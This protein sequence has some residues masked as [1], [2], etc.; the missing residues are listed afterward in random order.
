VP[1]GKVAGTL[2]QHAQCSPNGGV[3]EPLQEGMRR[4]HPRPGG[5]KLDRQREPVEPGAD[6]RDGGGVVGGEG[7]PRAD[8]RRPVDEERDGC[9]IGQR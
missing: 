4:Q 3:T 5:G 2:R 6:G 8:P 1:E 7:E 9:V